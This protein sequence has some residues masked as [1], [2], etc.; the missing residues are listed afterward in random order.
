MYV[1]CN[2]GIQARHWERMSAV[3]GFDIM[4]TTETSLLTFLDF[5]LSEHLE[6]LE[7]IAGSAAKEH[8]LETTLKKMKAD[9]GSMRFELLPYRDTVRKL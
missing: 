9:W 4:P 2:P 5:G 3:V 6:K 7:E 8:K 1:V